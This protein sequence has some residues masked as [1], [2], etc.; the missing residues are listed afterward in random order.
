MNT[1]AAAIGSLSG[2]TAV[3]LAASVALAD[4][5][6]AN[7]AVGLDHSSATIGDAVTAT[8]IVCL[9]PDDS[10]PL[11]LN[12]TG[13]WLSRD[14][15][16]AVALPGGGGDGGRLANDLPDVETWLPFETVTGSGTAATGTATFTVP[17]VASGSYQLWWHCENGA[18]PGSGIHYSGGSRLRVHTT[19]PNTATEATAPRGVPAGILLLAAVITAAVA[20]GTLRRGRPAGRRHAQDAERDAHP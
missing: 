16:P 8:G 1:R 4:T 17:A 7:T 6:C 12:L 3:L 19:G 20:A 15:L 9:G 14:R 18:G 2:L 5:C 11:P 13:F 10:G